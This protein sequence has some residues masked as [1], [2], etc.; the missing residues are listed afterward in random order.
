VM[1][2]V[3]MLSVFA[4]ASFVGL[5]GAFAGGFV[6]DIFSQHFFGYWSLVAVLAFC[7]VSFF[8]HTYVRFPLLKRN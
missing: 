8:T 4:P 2:V 6:L 3:F 5:L 1:I 7:A